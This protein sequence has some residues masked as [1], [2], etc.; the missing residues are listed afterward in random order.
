M[1]NKIT[2]I[3]ESQLKGIIRESVKRVLKEMAGEGDNEINTLVRQLQD[4]MRECGRF[5]TNSNEVPIKEL[6]L[7]ANSRSFGVLHFDT[8]RVY[9]NGEP[10]L[11]DYEHHMT[12]LYGPNGKYPQDDFEYNDWGSREGAGIALSKL[13]PEYY[14]KIVNF[15]KGKI[16][17]YTAKKS[18]YEQ[19]KAWEAERVRR[20][21]EKK[22]WFES[23]P[24]I[25]KYYY[26]QYG[27][28][29]YEKAFKKKVPDFWEGFNWR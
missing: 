14:E 12:S 18:D 1:E 28:N 8:L 16:E 13:G 21:N 2:R 7:T 19:E 29:E 17:E 24:F 10:S 20:E 6:G 3:G 27:K 23:L 5:Y 11:F 4:V 15:L 26:K 25:E 22:K 9:K